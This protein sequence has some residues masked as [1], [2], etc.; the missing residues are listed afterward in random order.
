MK[1]KLVIANMPI[2]GKDAIVM[3]LYE[4]DKAVEMYIRSGDKPSVLN[5]I[6]V[7]HVTKVAPGS[8]GVFINFDGEHEGYMPER[9]TK[10]AF[11]KT[12][13]KTETI[14]AEDELLVL[15]D[16]EPLKTK[17]TGL[18]AELSISGRYVVIS[19]GTDGIVFSSKLDKTE[20]DRIFE[21]L[22][23][24][25][26]EYGLI[27]RTAASEAAEEDIRKEAEM[28]EKK[29]DI[30]IN[31]GKSRPY[32][33]CLHKSGEI[34]TEKFRQCRAD[35][36]DCIVTDIPEIYEEFNGETSEYF[37]SDDETNSIKD[38]IRLYDDKMLA[39]YKLYGLSSILDEA[40]SEK[41]WLKS[42]GY[43]VIQQTEAFVC[44]D[45]N[46]GKADSKSKINGER[47]FEL[48]CEA[49]EEAFRQIRLRQLSGTILIDFINMKDKKFE[50]D[51][52]NIAKDLSKRDSGSTKIIDIT[53][54]GIMEVTRRKKISS[55]K[56]QICSN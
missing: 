1:Q 32:G 39:L 37:G 4:N 41:V 9:K 15:A 6:Y 11:Y 20:K 29:L 42:G 19:T 14:K 28:L 46:S 30:I 47:F 17:L 48:N 25:E 26:F 31:N 43:I 52:L 5:N 35:K 51:L 10:R 23:K 49:A 27:V 7:G 56:E 13:K 34:W 22:N 33:T 8:G 3:V 55:L 50:K 38:K 21:C 53:S 18:T 40:L 45:V 36:L 12:D 24:T 2:D 44:I 54:L 16:T